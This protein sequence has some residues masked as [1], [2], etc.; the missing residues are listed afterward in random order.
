[1]REGDRLALTVDPWGLAG[2]VDGIMV[3]IGTRGSADC[4]LASGL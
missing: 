1:M 2:D 4:R 3:W